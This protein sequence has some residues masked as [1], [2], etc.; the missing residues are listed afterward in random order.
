MNNKL[1]YDS[2]SLNTSKSIYLERLHKFAFKTYVNAMIGDVYPLYIDITNIQ[3]NSYIE[4]T[5]VIPYLR[6]PNS[7]W[8]EGDLHL[9]SGSNLYAN[10]TLIPTDKFSYLSNV[11]ADIQSQLNNRELA[12]T[13]IAPLEQTLDSV[14]VGGVLQEYRQLGLSQPFLN[15]VN[16]KAPTNNPTF[17][18][19]V[20]GITKSMVGLSNV[21]NTS[22]ENKPI[23]TAVQTA[24][25]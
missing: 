12:F 15:T 21:G 6:S 2:D 23:S 24:L 14:I 8:V 4:N 10:N 16:G 1:G 3:G 25:N 22:D 7:I 20:S 11:T 17:T 9:V 13:A 18:G 19:T 5:V